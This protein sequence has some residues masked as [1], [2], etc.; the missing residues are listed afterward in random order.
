MELLMKKTQENAK[1]YNL[2]MEILQ[3]PLF[4]KKITKKIDRMP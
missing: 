1:P 3:F 2:G 4:T